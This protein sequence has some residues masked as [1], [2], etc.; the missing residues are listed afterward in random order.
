[1]SLFKKKEKRYP[2][3]NFHLNQYIETLDTFDSILPSNLQ[4]IEIYKKNDFNGT[5]LVRPYGFKA[6][7][8]NGVIYNYPIY[9]DTALR[10]AKCPGENDTLVNK[11]IPNDLFQNVPIWRDACCPVFTLVQNSFSNYKKINI[12]LEEVEKHLGKSARQI[13]EVEYY[14]YILEKNILKVFNSG[15]EG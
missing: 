15:H 11:F 4:G 2:N 10:Q 6:W 5:I 12:P 13:E 9:V 8:K 7:I 14:S 1:M 3:D